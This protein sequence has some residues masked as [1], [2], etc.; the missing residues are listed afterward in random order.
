MWN[1]II[2]PLGEAPNNVIHASIKADDHCDL[3]A[4]HLKNMRVSFSPS[5][6]RGMVLTLSVELY[7]TTTVDLHQ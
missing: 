5:S 2:S 7:G 3:E 1:R 6:L 4:A